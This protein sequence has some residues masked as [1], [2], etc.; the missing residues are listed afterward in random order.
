MVAQGTLRLD[1]RDWAAA[2][3]AQQGST[4]PWIDV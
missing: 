1:A 4:S 2:R 3:G